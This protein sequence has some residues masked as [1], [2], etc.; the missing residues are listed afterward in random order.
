MGV[1][2]IGAALGAKSVG[3]GHRTIAAGNGRPASTVRG[4]LRWAPRPGRLQATCSSAWGP[5]RPKPATR[6]ETSSAAKLVNDFVKAA[7]ERQR[8][9]T[10]ISMDIRT[11][12]DI[13]SPDLLVPRVPP[14]AASAARQRGA[15]RM[16][17]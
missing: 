10:S 2:V 1:A 9:L 16:D 7:D 13:A 5:P 15:G 4:W 8:V 17:R 6:S 12:C 14:K 11:Y 3:A